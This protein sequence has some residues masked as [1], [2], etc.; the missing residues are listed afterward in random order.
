MSKVEKGK[1]AVLGDR[2]TLPLFKSAGFKTVEV[3]SQSQAVEAVFRLS[4][5]QEVSLI[6]VLKHVLSDEAKFKQQV[7]HS[8]V[9]VFVLPT[10][11][12]PGEKVDVNKIL[13]KALGMG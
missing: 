5:S 12:A 9:P 7:A 11:H 10:L 3:L 13:A 1:V 8:R 6:I 4:A 2:D